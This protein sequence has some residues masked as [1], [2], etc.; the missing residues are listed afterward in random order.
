MKKLS[1]NFRAMYDSALTSEVFSN[2][3]FDEIRFKE[4]GFGEL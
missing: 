3:A 1:L 2:F 4:E